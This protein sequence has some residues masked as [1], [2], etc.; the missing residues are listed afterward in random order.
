MKF[1]YQW[2]GRLGWVIAPLLA[3]QALGGAVLLWMQPLPAAHE[4]PPAI[5]E[6]ARAVDAGV[7]ELASRYPA[8]KIEYI[9]LPREPQAPV[10]VRLL[11]S[12][13]NEAG[14]ADIDVAQARAGALKPDNSQAKTF[15]Y[16]LHEHMLLDDAGPWVMRVMAVVALVLVFMG[17]RVW[18]KVRTLAPRSAWRRVHRAIGPVFIAPLA[19]MLF[20]GFVLRSP[21]WA[22]SVAAMWP[23]AAAATPAA[24]AAATAPPPAKQVATLGQAL[25]TA[26][27]TL[28]QSRPIRIYP[29]SKGVASVRMRGEEWHPLGL[30]RVFVNVADASAPV[31]RIVRASEQPLTV[32]YLNVIYPLHLGWLPGHPSVAA[33]L[34][35]RVLWTLLA[36]SLAGLAISG[37]VQRFRKTN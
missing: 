13:S 5:Q 31:K 19:M 12:P 36:L 4:S 20:T 14:W 10:S 17:L 37:A 6:W 28:P 32:R 35:V 15:L 1:S 23:A 22:R 29:A 27:A 2:H 24:S 26:A 34:A 8:A 9:N 30:D 21:D 11:A 3:I 7:A 33:T 18:F 25:T 16:N